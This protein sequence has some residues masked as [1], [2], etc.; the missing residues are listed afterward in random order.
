MARL[1]VDDAQNVFRIEADGEGVLKCA[2]DNGRDPA[3][4]A[5]S[6]RFVFAAALASFGCDYRIDSQ[7][8]ISLSK[9]VLPAG[10]TAS[11]SWVAFVL[12][13]SDPPR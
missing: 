8:F 13:N 11:K 2:V 4:D 1:A 12:T 6:P 5:D 10:S 9:S 3:S 7:L